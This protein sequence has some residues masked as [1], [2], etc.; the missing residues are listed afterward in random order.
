M[1]NYFRSSVVF[2]VICLFLAF[3]IGYLPGHLLTQALSSVSVCVI[4]ALLEISLSFD[5]AVVNASIL[6]KMNR[7]WQKRFLTWGMLIAVFGMRLVFPLLIVSISAHLGPVK[8]IDLA[9]SRP[10][11]YARILTEAHTA[12]MGFGGAFLLMVG[13]GFFFDKKKIVHW[14]GKIEE[15]LQKLSVCKGIE[16]VIVLVVISVIARILPPATALTFLSSAIFGLITFI[17]VREI[18]DIL[19][20]VANSVKKTAQAGFGTFIYLEIMDA[21]F[22]FDGVIGS[23]ALTTNLFLIALGLGIGA[24]FVRSL[25]L[26][27]VEKGTLATYQ[28]L[29]HGAFW[30]ILA[31]A[32]IML[33]STF[34]KIPEIV[35]GLTGVGLIGAALLSSIVSKKKQNEKSRG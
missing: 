13:F 26:I 29:E 1:L 35:T 25:T 14:F 24:M 8:A 6:Q 17:I 11:D 15:P 18:G 30:A 12:I 4:L 20:G 9:I 16:S 5:N 7:L 31:L 21:S 32:V 27:L 2:T 10:E 34:Y 3:L 33:V 28:Y 22:S 23:F 19:G